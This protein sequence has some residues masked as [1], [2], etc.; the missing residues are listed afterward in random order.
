LNQ[1]A[2][3]TVPALFISKRMDVTLA[4]LMKNTADALE[5]DYNNKLEVNSLEF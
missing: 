4:S 1:Q 3:R 5:L 2:R